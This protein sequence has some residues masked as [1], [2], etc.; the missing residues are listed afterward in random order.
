MVSGGS[1]D[2]DGRVWLSCEVRAGDRPC[3]DE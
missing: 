1:S 2:S 3:L